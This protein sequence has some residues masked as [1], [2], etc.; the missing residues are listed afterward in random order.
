MKKVQFIASYA[1]LLTC[2]LLHRNFGNC[3][4]IYVSILLAPIDLLI[5]GPKQQN[6]AMVDEIKALIDTK[7]EEPSKKID[8]VQDKSDAN[9]NTLRIAMEKT[10]Q[11]ARKV[12]D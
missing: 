4:S 11:K 1:S 7:F 12:I 10:D 2:F 8:T 3:C 5:M 9:H 6:N